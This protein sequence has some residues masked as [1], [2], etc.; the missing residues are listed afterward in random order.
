MSSFRVLVFAASVFSFGA[1]PLR[2]QTAGSAPLAS[3]L[4]PMG[5]LVGSCW[6]GTFSNRPAVSDEHCFQPMLN[7]KFIRDRHVVRGDSV[8]YEGESVYGWDPRQRAVVFTYYA[9][10]GFT[11]T[12][13]AV[14]A[15]SVITFPNTM[16]TPRGP[17][18]M[19]STWRRTGPDSYQVRVTM[20]AAGVTR[21]LWSMELR[22]VR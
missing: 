2:A 21:E 9:L 8:P 3:Y 19:V 22:R 4:Q 16:E 6:R 17:Q 5:W 7:G 20:T 1:V 15:D 10:P 13:R 11:M 18:E 14:F 12:G